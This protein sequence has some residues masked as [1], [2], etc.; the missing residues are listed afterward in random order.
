MLLSP[1][2]AIRDLFEERVPLIPVGWA[3]RDPFV[4]R[5][6]IANVSSPV[7]LIHGAN[8]RLIPPEHA[9]HLAARLGDRA[10]LVLLPGRDHNDLWERE[11]TAEAIARFVE[12]VTRR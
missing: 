5:D 11:D 8:D 9:E 1:F 6:R 10:E 4:T 2:T 7:L 3:V 12:R